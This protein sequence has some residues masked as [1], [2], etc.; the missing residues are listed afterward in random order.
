MKKIIFASLITLLPAA[1]WADSLD[2]ML[3]KQRELANIELEN[4]INEAKKPNNKLQPLPTQLTSS[5][6][7]GVSV[8]VGSDLVVAPVPMPIER[9]QLDMNSI[10]N[11]PRLTAVYGVGEKLQ[12]EVQFGD[13]SMPLLLGAIVDGWKLT[14]IEPRRIVFSKTLSQK[15]SH[16]RTRKINAIPKIAT[17]EFYLTS[18]SYHGPADMN[19]GPS[20]STSSPFSSGLSVTSSA[21]GLPSMPPPMP[22]LPR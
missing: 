22:A 2:D 19:A 21:A 6:K 1:A 18:A 10:D 13:V 17:R 20:K 14:T 3:Q 8:S 9:K 11:P 4:K 12:A 15:K 7:T 5:N 16:H